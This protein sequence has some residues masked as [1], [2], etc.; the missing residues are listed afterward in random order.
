VEKTGVLKRVWLQPCR[1]VQAMNPALAAEASFQLQNE[2]VT[3]NPHPKWVCGFSIFT[4]TN[5]HPQERSSS[6]IPPTLST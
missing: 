6:T 3:C 5:F 4:L 1:K 2:F